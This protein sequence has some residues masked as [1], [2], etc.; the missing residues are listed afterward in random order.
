[1]TISSA[2]TPAS[3]ARDAA[4]TVYQLFMQEGADAARWGHDGRR[5]QR[6]PACRVDQASCKWSFAPYW[7]L[8]SC[9]M[10]S[11]ATH[12]RETAFCY[13]TCASS[14]HSRRPAHIGS[15]EIFLDLSVH[16]SCTRTRL[17]S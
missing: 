9:L 10:R 13:R 4:A 16:T 15:H 6:V 8:Q 14:G 2:L 5:R 1:M 7:Q 12:A 17:T 11:D 3:K